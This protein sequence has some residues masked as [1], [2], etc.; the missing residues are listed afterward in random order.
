MEHAKRDNFVQPEISVSRCVTAKG[1]GAGLSLVDPIKV[2]A[3]K[4]IFL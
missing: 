1:S 3:C 4:S 2:K